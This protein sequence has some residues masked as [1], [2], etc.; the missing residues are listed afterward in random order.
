MVLIVLDEMDIEGV[1]IDFLLRN[2]VNVDEFCEVSISGNVISSILE[3]FVIFG[4][5]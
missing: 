2:G 5:F 1:V 4:E 3:Y